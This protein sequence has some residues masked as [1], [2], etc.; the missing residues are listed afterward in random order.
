[1]TLMTVLKNH[2]MLTKDAGIIGHFK[3]MSKWVPCMFIGMAN[4]GIVDLIELGHLV[5]VLKVFDSDR[6]EMVGVN[7]TVCLMN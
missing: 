3:R 7:G 1:M 6:A 2:L 4:F 5:K